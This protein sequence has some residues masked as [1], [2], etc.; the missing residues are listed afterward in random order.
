M[1]REIIKNK[2]ALKLRKSGLSIRSIAK[3]LQISTSTASIW[4]RDII[5]STEQVEK[6]HLKAHNTELLRGF[7]IKRHEEKVTRHEEIFENAKLEIQQLNKSEFF[8]VGLAL[9]W[10]EGFKN[11]SEGRLGFCN[12]DPKMIKLIIK[13]FTQ[14]LNISIDNLVL[15]V[16]INQAH[17]SRL[18]EIEMHWSEIAGVPLS[19][20]NKPFLQKTKHLRDYSKRGQYY[21]VL[22]IKVRKSLN[23]L[24]KLKGWTE[25]LSLAY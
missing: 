13:W 16:E 3:E 2:K 20:F 17:A 1:K 7:A 14:T 10:A 22:R 19:Q 4:C 18:S 23:L 21:G 11:V 25:G 5:L 8:F 12:S 9:Y 6:L 24:V 15:R